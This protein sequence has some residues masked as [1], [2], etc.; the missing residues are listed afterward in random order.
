[1]GIEISSETYGCLEAL[2]HKQ[3]HRCWDLACHDANLGRLAWAVYD[4]SGV[5]HRVNVSVIV[6]ASATSVLETLANQFAVNVA[7]GLLFFRLLWL[8]HGSFCFALIASIVL[9]F[10]GIGLNK[11]FGNATPLSTLS[12][13]ERLA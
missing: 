7:G 3:T 13:R 10:G 4:N 8:S 2:G 11:L 6:P 1:M 9:N 12:I 5:S